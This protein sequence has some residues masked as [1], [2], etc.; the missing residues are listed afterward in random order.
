MNVAFS[1]VDFF[2]HL[3]LIVWLGG[4][5]ILSF[6]VA[7]IVFGN[8]PRKEAGGLQAQIFR[9]FYLFQF[10]A[11]LVLLVSAMARYQLWE[12]PEN[13]DELVVIRL[14]LI[15]VMSILGVFQLNVVSKRLR[16]LREEITSWEPGSEDPKRKAFGFWHK[17]SV[18]VTLL[19]L[20]IGFGVLFLT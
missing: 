11:M 1:T 18:K 16:I 2:Y 6:I 15:F 10:V 12:N 9:R 7:P 20:L 8:L 4:I 19:I 5:I 3:S 13:P 14:I 17:M